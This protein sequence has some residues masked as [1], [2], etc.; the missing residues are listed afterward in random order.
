MWVYGCILYL[1]TD[2]WHSLQM[3]T[4]LSV[5]IGLYVGIWLYNVFKYLLMAFTANVQTA[6]CPDGS[7]AVYYI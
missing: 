6:V 5:L 1:N 2:S 7:V 3:Y 4:R